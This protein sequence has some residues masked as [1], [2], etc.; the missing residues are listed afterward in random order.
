MESENLKPRRS[1]LP[2][3]WRQQLLEWSQ[4][5]LSQVQFCRER[6]LSV[7]AFTWWK[8]KFR[9]ELNL[10][11]RRVRKSSRKRDGFIEVQVSTDRPTS[12]YELLL[13]NGRRIT[14]PTRF[15]I[16]TLKRLI[17]VAETPC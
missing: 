1:E 9:D 5:G 16:E 6:K 15:D 8:A 13:T 3:Y 7:A 2:G 11:Y 4:S 17:Q 12:G 10:P 14:I